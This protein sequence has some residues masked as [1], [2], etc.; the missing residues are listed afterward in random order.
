MPDA[1]S[2]RGSFIVLE[3]PDGAGK[4]VQARQLADR[5]RARGLT[6]TYSR[7]PGGTALYQAVCHPPAARR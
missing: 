7:E 1:G 3:G 2:V 5:L 4:S 6:V